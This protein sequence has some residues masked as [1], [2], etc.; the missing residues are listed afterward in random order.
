ML[1]IVLCNFTYRCVLAAPYLACLKGDSSLALVF[2]VHLFD[3]NAQPQSVTINTI[4]GAGAQG[5]Y[6]LESVLGEEPVISINA[7]NDQRKRILIIGELPIPIQRDIAGDATLYVVSIDNEKVLLET[8]YK[9][10]VNTLKYAIFYSQNKKLFYNNFLY[11]HSIILFTENRNSGYRSFVIRTS[12][13][14]I[15]HFNTYFFTIPDHNGI[16]LSAS[17][18]RNNMSSFIILARSQHLTIAT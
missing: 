3:T 7:D 5:P 8:T 16:Y 6:K 12:T 13:R 18:E 9:N 2:L 4:F 15:N 10:G 1:K 17:N 14:F 11:K